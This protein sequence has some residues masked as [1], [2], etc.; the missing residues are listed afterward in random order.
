M[1]NHESISKGTILLVD[2]IPENLQLLSD[3]LLKHNYIV[4]RVTSGK[5]AL[6]TVKVKPPDVILLDIKM[7]EMN[8]YEV[9]QAFKADQNL[10]DIPIIFISALDEAFDKVKAFEYGG[11]DYITKPFHIEEVL[12]R[13]ENQLT[14]QRQKKA[15]K[16]E[17]A[18]R[19]ESET[20]FANIFHNSPDPVWIAT[21]AEGRCLNVNKRLCQFLGFTRAE[22]LN[23]TY[24]EL[25]IW[26]NLYDFNYFYQTLIEEGSIQ[27]FEVVLHT[28]SQEIKNVLLSAKTEKFNGENCVI[29]VI[30]DITILKL[31]EDILAEQRQM[32]SI[33]ISNLPG[34]VYRRLNDENWTMKF[35]TEGCKLVT[36]YEPSELQN[37][38]VVAYGNLIHPEDRDWLWIKCQESLDRQ[39]PYKNQYRIIDNEGKIRWVYE[40]AQGKYAPDGTSLIIEGFIQDISEQ[41]A[42]L[43]ERQL[44][45]FALAK[46]K[47]A[48][49]A[50][51]RAKSQFLANMS[52]EIRTYMNGVL[53]MAQLVMTTNLTTQQ[54]G[55][56]QTIEDGCEEILTITNHILDFSQMESDVN[57]QNRVI[58][59]N[60]LP[61]QYNMRLEKN[62][63]NY[64]EIDPQMAEKLPLRI[65]LAEHNLVNQK[66]VSQIFKKLGYEIDVV[67]NG[68]AALAAVQSESYDFVFM[69]IQMPEMDGLTLTREI[70][71]KL[72]VVPQIVAI[73]TK[74]LAEDYNACL[75]AGMDAYI[76]Q[77]IRI[78][79]I[80]RVL[81]SQPC[82]F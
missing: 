35:V 14:I 12:A 18:K 56:I 60:H 41:Q 58:L 16:D 4:R 76:T 32:L 50:A 53:S 80:V 37:N 63:S 52:H 19:Q 27:N 67:S 22:I 13:L 81:Y 69:N 43:Y 34:M 48:A 82:P 74:V 59:Q 40:Q 7:P 9:C 8:G 17:I 11:V 21:L 73:M 33:L 62:C 23:K 38:Q 51:T 30:Q 49:E 42:A 45:E 65:L 44:A 75:D 6:K 39:I 55:F 28:K 47:A 15:L 20:R 71:Q 54:Q 64:V 46:A 26:D 10:S 70:R 5:M 31:T 25:G 72:T 24:V 78:N 57:L 36:G 3:I 66:V 77:P 29:G 61:S 79:E 2:D 1:N 68:M